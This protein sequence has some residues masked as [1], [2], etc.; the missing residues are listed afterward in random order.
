METAI[1]ERRLLTLCIT[2]AQHQLRAHTAAL[3]DEREIDL[4]QL[5]ST[6]HCHIAGIRGE[7]CRLS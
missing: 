1:G 2:L 7:G 4:G 3:A 5:Q 6:D